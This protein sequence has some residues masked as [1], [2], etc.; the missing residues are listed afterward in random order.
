MTFKEYSHDPP[1]SAWENQSLWALVGVWLQ[2]WN[3]LTKPC[4]VL[5]GLR[6]FVSC[7]LVTFKEW[8]QQDQLCYS[9]DSLG[10]IRETKLFGGFGWC[11]V[12]KLKLKGIS[13]RE[14]PGVKL[15]AQFDSTQETSPDPT[16]VLCLKNP[17]LPHLCDTFHP[18]FRLLSSRNKLS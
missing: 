16:A 15:L 10:S 18:V 6:D 4:T 8:T 2:S 13:G 5:W 17:A 14:P 3:S 12:V 7:F 9:H 1:G 11:M